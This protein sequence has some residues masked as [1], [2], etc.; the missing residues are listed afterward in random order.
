MLSP[1]IEI[2]DF[3]YFWLSTFRQFYG[4]NR[5]SNED[6]TCKRKAIMGRNGP[7]SAIP[8]FVWRWAPRDHDQ[9]PFGC[10]LRCVQN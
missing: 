4:N 2:K 1:Q 6:R 8:A 3:E 10:N 7:G 5:P 9:H